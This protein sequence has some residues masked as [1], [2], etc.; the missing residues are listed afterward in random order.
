MNRR[1]NDETDWLDDL[2]RDEVLRA[3][4]QRL[5]RALPLL[6]PSPEFA[7]RLGRQ[8]LAQASRRADPRQVAPRRLPRPFLVVAAALSVVGAALYLWQSRSLHHPLVPLQRKP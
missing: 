4:A 6:S 2:G 3:V 5:G 7:D 1:R 8:L